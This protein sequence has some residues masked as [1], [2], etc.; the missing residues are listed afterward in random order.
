MATALQMEFEG[1]ERVIV[2]GDCLMILRTDSF[3]IVHL[4]IL[5]V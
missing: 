1:Y 3:E 5:S 2:A 4:R